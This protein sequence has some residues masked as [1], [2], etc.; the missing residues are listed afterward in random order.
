MSELYWVGVLLVLMWIFGAHTRSRDKR[1][2]AHR[3]E[4]KKTVAAESTHVSEKRE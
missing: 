2:K 3:E 4:R 1:R